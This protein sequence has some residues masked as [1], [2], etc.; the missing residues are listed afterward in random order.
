M[1]GYMLTW[2]TYGSWLQ[3][4]ERGWVKNG[5]V[6]QPD[7]R[8]YLTNKQ[9][10][11]STP[12]KLNESQRRLV[13]EAIFAESKKINH[14]IYA[15]AVC[16]NHVHIVA[17]PCSESISRIVQRYKRVSTYTL[18]KNGF[19]GKVWTKGYDKRYCFNAKDLKNVINYVSGQ[20]LA[21]DS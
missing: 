15:L 5:K 13:K 10:L 17:E 4:D 19:N 12:V 8:L 9:K 14:R 16:S 18:Q 7:S 11:K 2:T 6:L 3:G 1:I 21:P 20:I